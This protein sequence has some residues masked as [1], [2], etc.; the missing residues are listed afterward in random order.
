MIYPFPLIPYTRSHNWGKPYRR[1][2]AILEESH[3]LALHDALARGLTPPDGTDKHG[4]DGHKA[5]LNRLRG[6][7]CIG[8]RGVRKS[9]VQDLHISSV[10]G[11]NVQV[12]IDRLG[13]L[14]M[15]AILSQDMMRGIVGRNIR[16]CSTSPER[17]GACRASPDRVSGSGD[18]LEAPT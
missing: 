9:G 18:S 17:G 12:F 16:R 13:I 2:T 8:V 14:N 10:G 4:S 11:E 5:N 1:A 6:I 7:G 3:I 15:M